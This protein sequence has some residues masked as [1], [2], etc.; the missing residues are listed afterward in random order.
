MKRLIVSVA[1]SGLLAPASALAQAKPEIMLLV[2]TSSSMQLQ[3]GNNNI[4]VCAPAGT[5]A[6]DGRAF[7]KSR[8]MTTKEVLAGESRFTQWCVEETAEYRDQNHT[9]GSDPTGA[10]HFRSICCASGGSI[11]DA[12]GP[13]GDDNGDDNAAAKAVDEFGFRQ[14]LIQRHIE[15]VKFGLMSFDSVPGRRN[16]ISGRL[17]NDPYDFGARLP[18]AAS[19]VHSVGDR[20]DSFVAMKIARGVHSPNLGIR[21]EGAPFGGLIPADKFVIDGATLRDRRVGE[22][23]G[24]VE[25]H[26]RYVIEQLRRLVP[27]G[28][29]PTAAALSDAVTHFEAVIQAEDANAAVCRQRYAVLMTDGGPTSFYGGQGCNIDRECQA[30]GDGRGVCVCPCAPGQ[31]CAAIQCAA[32]AKICV[33]PEGFPYKKGAEYAA[34]LNALGVPLFVIGMSLDPAAKAAAKALA[35][36]GSPELGPN[37]GPGYFDAANAA[38]MEIALARVVNRALAGIFSRTKPLVM[39]PSKGDLDIV[40][41]GMG[42]VKQWRM[43][44]FSRAPGLGDSMRYGRI[45]SR[46]LGCPQRQVNA[47]DVGTLKTLEI[48]RYDERLSRLL[49]RRTISRNPL[50]ATNLRVAGGAGQTM[51]ASNGDLANAVTVNNARAMTTAAAAAGGDP[52]KSAGLLVNGY[53]GDEGLPNGVSGVLGVRQLGETL[54]GDLVAVTSP[55]DGIRSPAYQAFYQAHKDRPTLVASGAADGQ[56]HLF[57]AADGREVVNIIP[58][59]AWSRLRTGQAMADGPLE[60]RTVAECRSLSGQG[61]DGCPAEADETEFRTLLVGGLGRGGPNVF[62]VDLTNVKDLS[63]PAQDGQLLTNTVFQSGNASRPYIWDLTDLSVADSTTQAPQMGMAVSRPVLTHV[64]VGDQ[65]RAAVIVGCGMNPGEAEAVVENSTAVG[66]CVLVLDAVKGTLIKVINT[67]KMTAAMTGSVAVYPASGIA[68]AE[69]A[70][71]GDQLGRMWR[72][73]LRS[74]SPDDWKME[75]AFPVANQATGFVLGRGAVDKPSVTTREDGRLVVVYGTGSFGSGARSFVVSFSDGV[76][77]NLDFEAEENWLL[78]LPTDE[79]LSGAPQTR[80]GVSLFTTIRAIAG[81]ICISK[82]GRLYGVHYFKTRDQPFNIDGQQSK[83]K[84][85][86]PVYG[87]NGALQGEGALALVLPP[88]RIAYGLAIATTPSCLD[89]TSS[90]T[91]IVLNLSDQSGGAKGAVSKA[92]VQVET[93]NGGGVQISPLGTQLFAQD[94]ASGLSVCLDCDPTGAPSGGA[95]QGAGPFPAAVTYWGST[96]TQ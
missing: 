43:T 41:R 78:P 38:E 59:L 7:S 64:R 79:V 60:T 93:V 57:R 9:L 28:F 6:P 32:D 33:Y 89:G 26:N 67:D 40:P 42:T 45:Q 16:T 62:G 75:I 8:M 22:A 44:S 88:G 81:D 86:I 70:F 5:A 14:G 10:S 52:V 87:P 4:P 55:R 13:C 12:W 50:D 61:A 2:D 51:F 66:R 35:A 19:T 65:V 25:G 84:P 54:E 77:A 21:S 90:R 29:S 72:L 63:K 56:I 95:T 83:A 58:R 30:A 49:S 27:W 3:P 94:N 92:G 68:A 36:V 37:D 71:I 74:T 20:D 39:S 85:S 11:C 47:D 73:D 34:E 48:Q 1:L 46:V 23:A 76:D 24:D 69:R 82:E 18:V 17:A 15:D 91:D 53:F 31:D 96:F 80:G